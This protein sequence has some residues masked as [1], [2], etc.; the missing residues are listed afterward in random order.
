LYS[1]VINDYDQKIFFGPPG[2]GKSYAA[3]MATQEDILFKTTIFPDYDYHTFTGSIMPV[4]HDGNITYDF[5]PGIFTKALAAAFSNPDKRVSLIIDEMTR[6]N[7]AGIFGDIFQLLDRDIEGMSESSINN[8]LIA[9]Y[10]KETGI[11]NPLIEQGKIYLPS[12]FSI[13]GTINTSDQNVFVM[14]TAF[15]RRFMFEYV[16]LDAPVSEDGYINDYNFKFEDGEEISWVNLYQ[17]INKF[18]MHNLKMP[19]D[20]QVGPFFIKFEGLSLEQAYQQL[21]N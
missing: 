7:I 5:N 10:I 17:N 8:D 16:G 4:V 14:D 1:Q 20:K 15:K 12:N 18:I 19:E 2:T 21:S 3:N 13:I 9:K 6:G 11:V